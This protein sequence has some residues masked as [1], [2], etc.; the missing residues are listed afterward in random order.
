VRPGF[1]SSRSHCCE[2][3]M[4]WFSVTHNALFAASKLVGVLID[5]DVSEGRPDETNRFALSWADWGLASC[6]PALSALWRS[7]SNDAVAAGVWAVPRGF[8]GGVGRLKEIKLVLVV[9]EPGDPQEYETYDENLPPFERLAHIFNVVYHCFST[10]RDRFYK[11]VGYILK[12][13]WPDLSFAQRMRR[14][15]ITESVLC[16]AAKEGGHVPPVVHRQCRDDYLSRQI[17][18]LKGRTIVA[19]GRKAQA[20]LGSVKGV[21][22]ATSV[23]PPGCNFKG[24]K[25]SWDCI[26]EIV[27]KRTQCWSTSLTVRTT[28]RT[29]PGSRKSLRR[30]RIVADVRSLCSRNTHRCRL[31][32]T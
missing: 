14:V 25:E 32:E 20:R 22:G 6:V 26:A 24:A 1:N 11:N 4:T 3:G 10:E 7:L 29:E 2:W 21:V 31:E 13:C 12:S 5:I 23:A 27:R 8:C 30:A 16:S 19:L 9:A 28:D 15:W 17:E 18:L